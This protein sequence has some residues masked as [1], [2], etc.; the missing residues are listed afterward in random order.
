MNARDANGV[1]RPAVFSLLKCLENVYAFMML[2]L[3]CWHPAR[4]NKSEGNR[5]R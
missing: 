2:V 5:S 1:R 4:A 3:G